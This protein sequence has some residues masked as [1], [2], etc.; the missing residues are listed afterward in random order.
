MPEIAYTTVGRNALFTGL[1]S[2]ISAILAGMIPASG[3]DYFQIVFLFSCLSLIV[4]VYVELK[5]RGSNPFKEG[6]FYTISAVN[7]LPLIG[8]FIGLGLLYRS[9]KTEQ[10]GLVAASGFFPAIFRIKANIL[11]IFLLGALL[12]VLFVLTSSR[13]GPYY[14]RRYRN[15]GSRN[16]PQMVCAA[17]QQIQSVNCS[18]E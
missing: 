16:I 3:N 8:P 12:L 10:G 15:Y 13:D 11:I 4:S 2:H 1:I 7:V 5:H 17:G 6:L 14:E 9:Q 18:Y